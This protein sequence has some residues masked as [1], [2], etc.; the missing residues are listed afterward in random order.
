MAGTTAYT[1]LKPR[2]VSRF[3]A[4][5]TFGPNSAEITRVQRIGYGAWFDEQFGLSA[6]TAHQ[7][8]LDTVIGA[9]T[10]PSDSHVANTFWK[11]A[12]IGS[13]Q[14]RQ[15]VAFALSQIFVVSLQDSTVAQFRR[16]VAS[17]LALLG[18][19][20]FGT[21]RS[22]IESVA[23]HPMM[24]IYLSHLANQKE[25]P[26]RNRVPDQNF[27]REI[28]QLMSIGLYELQPDGTQRLVSGQP[29][30]TYTNDDIV[31]LSRVFTG[32]SWAGPDKINDRFF[33]RSSARDPNR[34]ILPMQSYPQY[35]SISEKRFL[36]TVIPAGSTNADADLAVALDR[37]AAHPNVGPFL[38]RQLIQ[39]LVTS[40]PSPAYVGRVTAAFDAGRYT[41]GTWTIGS[42]ARGDLRATIAAVLLD[43]DARA[44]PSLNNP[45]F[46]RVREPVLRLANWMRAFTATSA[47]GNYLLG[48][49]DDPATSLG[50]SPMRS[51]SV[52]N[53]YRP[54]YVPPNTGIASAGLVAPEM[55]IITE[56]SVIGYSNFMRNAMSNGV[57]TNRDIQPDYTTALSLATK[58]DSLVNHLDLLLTFG[59]MSSATRTLIRDAVS[60]IALPSTNQAT[61]RRNR[62]MLAALCV[63]SSP[64]YLVQK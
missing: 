16:G 15:R 49:T 29:V 60:T 48:T 40:N 20:A 22:L 32:F 44:M 31:G 61:A 27:S 3:L 47:S 36:G 23:R 56:T 7:Q 64:D 46:G 45:N 57:G 4:Q 8:Y 6:Q 25:D 13:D 62:V 28:M 42:G 33:G 17:Y 58:P 19:E 51:P 9:G 11:Q 52:F 35:H 41:S 55:Q 37:L 53:F 12:T 30:E 2:D 18:R 21:Y 26:T 5:A 24:G 1:N 43:R 59:T 38:G 50:Q 14:L 34:D 54:G 63:M 39:R 10:S